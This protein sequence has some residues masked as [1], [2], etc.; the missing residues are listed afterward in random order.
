VIGTRAVLQA[1][2]K[3]AQASSV[4]LRNVATICLQALAP[5]SE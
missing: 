1:M 3:Y 2:H 4:Q 5:D